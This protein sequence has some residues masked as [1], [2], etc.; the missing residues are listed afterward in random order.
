MLDGDRLLREVR[1]RR[2]ARWYLFSSGLLLI[3]L[4]AVGV[5]MRL[6][7]AGGLVDAAT[8]YSMM[9]LHGTGM[10]GI[11]LVAGC[12]LY[13]FVVHETL[14]VSPRA[15]RI[16][17]GLGVL[18]VGLIVVA[19]LAGGYD[20][21]WTFLYPL[22][23]HPGGT[24]AW[25]VWAPAT[26]LVG[27]ALL[28]VGFM[29]W[30]LDIARAVFAHYGSLGKALGF[31]VIAHGHGAADSSTPVIMAGLV[32]VTAGLSACVVGAAIVVMSLVNLAFPAFHV[33]PLLAK[34]MIYF[35]GHTLANIQIY[36]AVALVYAI[37]PFYAKRQWK[38]TR[39]VAIA[40][41]VTI[42]IVMLAF[43]HHL[44]QDFVQAEALQWIGNI[45][46]YS[47]AVPP[48]AVTIFGCVTLVYRS[49]IRWSA[50]PLFLY[51]GVM[52]WAAGGFG[53]VIDSTPSINQFLH[54]TQWVPAHFHT[55]MALG[56]MFMYIGA[57]YHLGPAL[58]G[59]T[60]SESRGRAAAILMSAGGYTLTGMWFYSGAM[61]EPRRYAFALPDLDWAA[62]IGAFG[63]AVALIGAVIVAWEL[64][65]TVTVTGPLILPAED[66]PT[67]AA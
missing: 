22:P 27:L 23:A 52:G 50:A 56:E 6:A 54:N 24:E 44:Y 12:A 4:A 61:G 33:D 14:P 55:Y 8:F 28:V 32:V 26:F 38:A 65:N 40:W 48:L 39:P 16:V 62:W 13:W 31:D 37:L 46:S 59:K 57:I 15:M 7:Q 17:W 60:L 58:L 64:L 3:A 47:A 51:L 5:F 2:I 67:W 10:I 30:C 41:L 1:S 21:A 49:A 34:N 45:A 43:F 63:A 66:E 36:M 42:S 9:S 11:A 20:S 53:A 35:T 18:G 29:V 19:I 25:G